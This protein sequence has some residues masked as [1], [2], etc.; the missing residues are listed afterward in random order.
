[1]TEWGESV[2]FRVR[3]QIGGRLNPFMCINGAT[4]AVGRKKLCRKH[5]GASR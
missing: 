4:V 1:M 3:C 5:A 2:R